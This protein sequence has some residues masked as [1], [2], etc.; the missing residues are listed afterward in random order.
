MRDIIRFEDT[1][2]LAEDI[3][4]FTAQGIETSVIAPFEVIE[5]L[6]K[7][8]VSIDAGFTFEDVTLCNPEYNNYQ[9]NYWLEVGS[10]WGLWIYPAVRDNTKIDTCTDTI[11]AH[12]TVEEHE[13]STS[14]YEYV[15][16]FALEDESVDEHEDC[17][18][19]CEHCPYG[20]EADDVELN[21]DTHGFTISGSDG[22]GTWS[23]SFYSTDQELVKEM[24]KLWR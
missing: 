10:D 19:D 3:I 4:E 23:H 17:D 15:Y 20:D 5:Q 6:V 1:Y 9:G 18:G 12:Y 13:Y 16:T 22:K 24:L 21:E 7:D 14:E 2:S 11:F 8:L